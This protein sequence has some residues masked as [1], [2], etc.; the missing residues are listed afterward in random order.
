MKKLITLVT[1]LAIF[2]LVG[3]SNKNN[4][5]SDIDKSEDKTI[6]VEDKKDTAEDTVDAKETDNDSTKDS[7]DEI[8][9]PL[10]KDED[11][12]EEEEE[13]IET[14]DKEENTETGN[15]EES[16]DNQGSNT[17][18][19]TNTVDTDVLSTYSNLYG[20]EHIKSVGNKQY[21]VDN[22]LEVTLDESYSFEEAAL[23]LEHLGTLNESTDGSG[24]HILVLDKTYSFRKISQLQDK[25]NKDDRILALVINIFDNS[26]WYGPMPIN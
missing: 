1:V 7:K 13:N 8:I 4:T 19:D 22:A 14:S 11:T 24:I 25:L 18:I 15:R 9:E 3:C 23:D 17:D 2:M 20:E 6:T 10:N 21:Y 12:S 16:T 5:V 26:D